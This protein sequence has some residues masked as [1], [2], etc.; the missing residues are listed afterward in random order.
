MSEVALLSNL[1]GRDLIVILA[2]ML[3]L[4]FGARRL[5]DIARAIRKIPAAFRRGLK[6][7]SDQTETASKDVGE[8]RNG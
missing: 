5:P 2:V 8:R 6:D 1:V 4:F 3:I 7:G